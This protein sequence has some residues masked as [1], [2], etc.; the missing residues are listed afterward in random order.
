MNNK[1]FFFFPLVPLSF[2]LTIGRLDGF[3]GFGGLSGPQ[4]T[5]ESAARGPKSVL[6]ESGA[7]VTAAN[8]RWITER[9]WPL[10]PTSGPMEARSYSAA[11]PKRV[12]RE[13][14]VD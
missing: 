6:M 12:G 7:R 14:K 4:E 5:P 11:G 1:T 3:G 8:G 2:S 10:Q 13:D 9:S